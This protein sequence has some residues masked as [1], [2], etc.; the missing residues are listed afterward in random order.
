MAKKISKSHRSIE[1]SKCL[2]KKLADLEDKL[3]KLE[4]NCKISMPNVDINENKVC[5]KVERFQS[6][7][8]VF[9]S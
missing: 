4:L 6:I 2:T 9:N 7:A 3:M 1:D 5:F 8:F